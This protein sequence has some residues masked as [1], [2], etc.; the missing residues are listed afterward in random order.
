MDRFD[1]IFQNTVNN[2]RNREIVI[3]GYSDRNKLVK[4][5]L[6]K[7]NLNVTFF[8]DRSKSIR[9]KKEVCDIEILK[10][11]AEKYFVIVK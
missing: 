4:N 11:G 3:Y 7:R 8:V 6:E 9:L 5:E 10:D 2:Y 1:Y